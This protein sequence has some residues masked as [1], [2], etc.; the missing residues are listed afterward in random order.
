M[1]LQAM[2]VKPRMKSFKILITKYVKK[3]DTFYALFVAEI[4]NSQSKGANG[5]FRLRKTDNRD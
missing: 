3:N 5:L 2:L 4:S 1:T